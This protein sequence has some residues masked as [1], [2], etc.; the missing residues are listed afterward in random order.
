MIHMPT[1]CCKRI[2]RQYNLSSK[3]PLVTYVYRVS[4]TQANGPQ[5][6]VPLLDLLLCLHVP[7][8]AYISVC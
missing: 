7:A 2:G 5:H 8:H 4:F 3:T 1:D 6:C